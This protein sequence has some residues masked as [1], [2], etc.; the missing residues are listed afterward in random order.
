MAQSWPQF[1]DIVSQ[2]AETF[3]WKS[4]TQN[5]APIGVIKLNTDRCS[6]E[7]P[8]CVVEGERLEIHMGE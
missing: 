8:E 6:K 1:F 3:L 5:P 7:I 2:V 4:V